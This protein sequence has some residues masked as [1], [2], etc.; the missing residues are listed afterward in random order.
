MSSHV[1]IASD[2][3]A[4]AFP[5]GSELFVGS[6][7]AAGIN[8]LFDHKSSNIWLCN[9]LLRPIMLGLPFCSPR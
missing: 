6:S 7:K 1:M 3:D 4:S 8:L 2:G 9:C 5:F